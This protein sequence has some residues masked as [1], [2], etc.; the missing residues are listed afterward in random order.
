MIRKV[1]P[2]PVNRGC[3]DLEDYIVKTVNGV[4]PKNM[5]DLARIIDTAKGPWLKI[6]TEDQSY[7]TLD[8]AK[9]REA[10]ETML[11]GFGIARDRSPDLFGDSPAM[12]VRN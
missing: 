10:Q 11:E 2:H 9:A 8:L 1:L 4:V 7:L 5:A 3:Q 12:Q 6:V